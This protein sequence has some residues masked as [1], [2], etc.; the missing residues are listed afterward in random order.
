MGTISIDGNLFKKMIIAGSNT[1]N[2][3][4]NEIDAMNVFPVPDGACFQWQFRYCIR[5]PLRR[6]PAR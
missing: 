4:R 6:V 3:C 5:F 1:L 2:K